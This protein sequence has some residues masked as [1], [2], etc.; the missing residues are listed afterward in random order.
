MKPIVDILREAGKYLIKNCY[1]I[2]PAVRDVYRTV[3]ELIN[4]KK[5]QNG[6]SEKSGK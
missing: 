4:D 3:K 1:W 6:K 2:I 5:K